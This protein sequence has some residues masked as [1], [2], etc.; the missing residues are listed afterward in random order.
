MRRLARLR[1]PARD[2]AHVAAEVVGRAQV[3]EALLDRRFAEE[4]R[5]GG[6]GTGD[7][8]HTRHDEPVQPGEV[9]R[10]PAPRHRDLAVAGRELRRRL[11]ERAVLHDE[12]TAEHRRQHRCACD[13]AD[14]DE[15]QSLAAC[16]E[17]GGDQ[18]E[19]EREP[20]KRVEHQYSECT[21]V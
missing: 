1:D 15:Q 8:L 6:S 19:R 4:H 18:A 3:D 16:A 12:P 2:E 9:V 5:R 21:G 20:A 7:L 13:H 17:T 10:R 11:G 14:G